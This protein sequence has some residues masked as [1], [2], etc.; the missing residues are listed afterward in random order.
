MPIVDSLFRQC[1]SYILLH[2]E[3]FPASQLSLLPLS[4]REDLLWQLPVADVCRLEDTS[5]FTAG[6][7][8]DKFW[9]FS[10]FEMFC[11]TTSPDSDIF[12]ERFVQEWPEYSR[13]I[14]Y[15]LVAAITMKSPDPDDTDI[16]QF[17]SPR[18]RKNLE[19]IP[20]MY[21]I[22]KIDADSSY[23]FPS[24]YSQESEKSE[25]DLTLLD[26]VRCFGRRDGDLPRIFPELEIFFG[27]KLDHLYI[28]QNT[29]YLGVMGVY[30]NHGARQFET[31][32]AILKEATELEYLFIEGVNGLGEGEHH[33]LDEWCIYLSTQPTF[34]SK[35]RMLKIYSDSDCTVSRQCFNQLVT[36]Y[37]AAPTDHV[38]KMA[39]FGMDIE[40]Y[41]AAYDFHPK[42]DQR[43]L[44]L[45]FIEFQYSRF[46]SEYEVTPTAI[47]H[48]LG[49]DIHETKD[50]RRFQ[51]NPGSCS[52]KVKE[53]IENCTK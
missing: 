43:Y 48:W 15:G 16:A 33:D 8:M 10:W 24:R 39:F 26:V 5:K 27:I 50:D 29:V 21:G 53:D 4:I 40:C 12:N 32:K 14:L 41:D 31:L 9:K 47:T 38:Q 25:K 11:A 1:Q 44:G 22:R 7:D 51:K 19:V 49:Q 20:F 52:F 36:A 23:V 37:F 30:F 28:F 17:R 35:F 46:I 6:L 45:K 13:T 18:A 42:I 3:E 34:L 2:L